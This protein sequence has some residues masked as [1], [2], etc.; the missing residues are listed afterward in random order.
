MTKNRV[1]V[2]GWPIEHSLSPAMHNAAFKVLGMGD[3][4]RYDLRAIPP[5]DLPSG[6]EEMRQM[7]YVGINVTVPHKQTVME[8]VSPDE[9][10]QAIGAVNTVDFRDNTGTNTDVDGF[11]ADLGAH[12]VAVSGEKVLVLGAGGAGRAVVYGL[13]REGAQIT[14]VEQISERAQEMIAHLRASVGADG[15]ET[16]SLAGAAEW[17]ASVIVNCTPVGMW[18][19]VDA[20]TWPVEI[21]FPQG[22]TVYDLVYRPAKT[23]LMQQAE[24]NGGRAFGGLGMLVRQGAAAFTIWT[25]KDAPF[26]VMFK[27]V[28]DVLE[29]R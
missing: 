21:P 19:K 3:N 26:D 16:K 1:G 5:D 9:K 25:G 14:V 12:G 4:W 2:I 27:I 23:R 29:K 11:I 13:W 15:I 7:G 8:L 18:P 22:V 6:V 28:R 10:A 20:S 17:G 24:D